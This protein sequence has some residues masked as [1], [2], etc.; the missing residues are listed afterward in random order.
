[1]RVLLWIGL[2]LLATNLNAE[3]V[4]VQKNDFAYGLPIE[5]ADE[6]A[7][8]GLELPEVVYTHVTKANLGD[9]RVFNAAGEVVPHSLQRPEVPDV[10]EGD[11][12]HVPFFPYA[13]LIY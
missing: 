8:Y 12:I 3:A 9:L 4:P 7:I 13:L 6:A 1:M 11:P 5:I 10:D 2:W